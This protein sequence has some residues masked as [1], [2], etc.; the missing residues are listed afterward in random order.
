MMN[1]SSGT[2]EGRLRA[3]SVDLDA[4]GGRGL[5]HDLEHGMTA[6]RYV[7]E[8]VR[9]DPTLSEESA[10]RLAAAARELD[11]LQEMVDGWL[12][13]TPE[14]AAPRPVPLRPLAGQLAAITTAER[15][16]DVT[17]PPGTDV[18]LA[19]EPSLLW[20][21]LSNVVDNAAR[22]A[23]G[24]GHVRISVTRAPGTGD[25]VVTVTDDGPGFGGAP[26]GLASL[27]LRVV[28]S[29]LASCGGQ[30]TLREDT[31]NGTTVEMVFPERF[32]VEVS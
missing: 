23:G 11:R 9:G 19:V 14:G 20:R 29:V 30:L 4:I 12:S 32:V 24:D 17:V 5:F 28:T 25:A 13:G 18:A 8:A 6:V 15:G 2:R 3:D 21:V 26:A 22:A 16:T 31:A 7:V 27:G 1:Q 10:A